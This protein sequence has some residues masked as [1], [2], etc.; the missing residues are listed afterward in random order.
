MSEVRFNGHI[1]KIPTT[2]D[3]E[4]YKKL[5]QIIYNDDYNC[6]GEFI[7]FNIENIM[8]EGVDE[9]L[10]VYRQEFIENNI[11]KYVVNLAEIVFEEESKSIK[12]ENVLET[13]SDRE[14]KVLR[15]YFGLD[16]KNPLTLQEI[17]EILNLTRERIRQIKERA[18]RR[19][20][21]HTRS[22]K[23]R[24]FIDRNK[25][26]ETKS[27]YNFKSSCVYIVDHDLE[28]KKEYLWG[29]FGRIIEKH[30]RS[31]RPC[32]IPFL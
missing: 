19:L 9:T 10:L 18:L 23:L 12:I 7:R 1:I 27:K 3:Y 11:D 30:E 22:R 32:W 20:R 6:N 21:H 2:I 15:Y 29:V 8:I 31:H 5:N 26:A 4:N 16:L 28:K 13:I 14:A 25:L 24:E 17:G